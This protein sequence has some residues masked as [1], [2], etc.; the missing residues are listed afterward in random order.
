M[1]LAFDSPR[2]RETDAV[3]MLSGWRLNVSLSSLRRLQLQH[4]PVNSLQYVTLLLHHKEAEQ[5]LQQ[6]SVNEMFRWV[7]QLL[8]YNPFKKQTAFSHKML[9][10]L[11]CSYKENRLYVSKSKL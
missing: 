4:F 11:T 10:E 2:S 9:I 7:I 5:L 1:I 6:T 3:F 8:I